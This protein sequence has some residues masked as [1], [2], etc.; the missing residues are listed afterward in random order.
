LLPL[1]TVVGTVLEIL[2]IPVL[3]FGF[4][5]GFAS[6]VVWLRGGT[7]KQVA[8]AAPLAAAAGFFAGMIV[9]LFYVGY[10]LLA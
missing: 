10:L 2:G 3:G 1:A 5:G 8:D 7:G 9:M 6:M 4:F